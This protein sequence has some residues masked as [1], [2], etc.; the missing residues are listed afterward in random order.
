MYGTL[1]NDGVA[2]PLL[3]WGSMESAPLMPYDDLQARGPRPISRNWIALGAGL[4]GMGLLAVLLL[5]TTMGGS[6]IDAVGSSRSAQGSGAPFASTHV[7][8]PSIYTLASASSQSYTRE[9]LKLAQEEAKKAQEDASD[10]AKLVEQLQQTANT[11]AAAQAG[12][13]EE[14]TAAKGVC[15]CDT[16]LPCLSRLWFAHP[17]DFVGYPLWLTKRDVFVCIRDAHALQSL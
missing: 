12:A 6:R 10:A 16:M 2:P 17:F 9:D 3:P 14:L 8:A 11:A 15:L 1:T 13:N 7:T 4:G 5:G